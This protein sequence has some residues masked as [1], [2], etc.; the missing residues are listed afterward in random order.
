MKKNID[1]FKM[2]KTIYDNYIE[3]VK[4]Y[5]I[6]ITEK[7]KEIIKIKNKKNFGVI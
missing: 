1:K 4:F 7:L 6:Y 5:G 3:E 2:N